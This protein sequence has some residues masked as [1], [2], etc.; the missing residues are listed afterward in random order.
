MKMAK[1]TAKQIEALKPKDKYYRKTVDTGLKIGVAKDGV[2]KWIVQ[3]GVGKQRDYRLSRV[4]G[5]PTNAGQLSFKDARTEAAA[6]RA[7]ARDGIDYQVKLQQELDAA[8]QQFSEQQAAEASRKQL[9]KTEN[10]TVTDLFD[11]WLADGVRRKD[12]NAELRRSFRKDVLPQIGHLQIKNVTEH[13]LRSVL[14]SMVNRG[15]NRLAVVTWGNLT[16]MFLWAEKRQ[17]WRKLLADGNPVE[18]IEIEKIV[19]PDYDLR[20]ERDRILSEDEIRELH[21]IFMTMR[22]EYEEASD[23]RIALRPVE[24]TTQCSLWIMLATLCRVGELSKARW[25]HIDF[26]NAIWFIPKE[27]TKGQ[28]GKQNALTVYLS[29]F[30]LAQFRALHA[31]TKDSDWCFPA[32]FKEGPISDKSI[33]KQ[34]GDRQT[35]FKKDRSGNPRPPMKNRSRAENALVLSGGKNGEWTPHDLRRTGATMMQRL[36]ISMEIIDRCQNHVLPG[37]KTRRHYLHH[38]YANETQEAWRRL[39]QKLELIVQPILT[40]VTTLTPKVASHV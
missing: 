25:E 17:P 36:G 32:T 5:N 19:S 16:Q 8:A 9:E 15:V 2:K 27:A 40:N 20:N 33:S 18:L 34:V 30:A 13:D 7:L 35:M 23:R 28:K 14:R 31:L 22:S 24:L 3:Y 12:G 39:G 1:F 4:Y 37:S 38:D 21:E 29:P 6:I 11:T 26:E 10:L